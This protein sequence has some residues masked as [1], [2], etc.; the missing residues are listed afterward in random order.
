MSELLG[1]HNYGTLIRVVFSDALLRHI[2]RLSSTAVFC[3][4]VMNIPINYSIK[5]GAV[6][7]ANHE[8]RCSI[9]S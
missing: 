5:N 2:V 7:H 8:N 9:S 6:D 3:R 1:F 4:S